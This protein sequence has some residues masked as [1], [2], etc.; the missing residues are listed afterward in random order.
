MLKWRSDRWEDS[1]FPK[2]SLG[3]SHLLV[4]STQVGLHLSQ[5]LPLKDPLRFGAVI[6]YRNTCYLN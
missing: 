5:K 4:R 6:C 1:G 2:H 3:Q